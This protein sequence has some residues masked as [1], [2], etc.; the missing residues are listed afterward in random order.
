MTGPTK[1]GNKPPRNTNRKVSPGFTAIEGVPVTCPSC[2]ET[3]PVNFKNWAPKKIEPYH[4]DICRSCQGRKVRHR[5]NNREELLEQR[6]LEAPEGI[7]HWPDPSNAPRYRKEYWAKVDMFATELYELQNEPSA[8]PRLKEVC[9]ELRKVTLLWNDPERGGYQTDPQLAYMTFTAVVSRW[10]NNWKEYGEIHTEDLIPALTADHDQILVIAT[11]NSGKS[12]LAE[13]LLTW[14]LFR[15]PL[16]IIGAVSGRRT[17]ARRTQMVVR[18]FINRCPLLRHLQPDDDCLDSAEQFVT[19][20]ANGKLG[21]SVSFSSFSIQSAMVGLRFN[22][23]LLDDVEVRSDRT[24]TAQQNLELFVGEVAH[25]LNP[26]GRIVALGT[27]QEG[28]G[29]SIYARWLKDD[30]WECTIA[31]MFTEHDEGKARPDLSTRWLARWSNQEL[32]DKRR[33]M[34]ERE[35]E[36]HWRLNMNAFYADERPLKLREFITV[37]NSAT[38]VSFPRIV[39][40][41]GEQL[42]HL[43]AFPT[44]DADDYF[45]GPAETSSDLS[46]YVNTTVGVDPASGTAGRDEVGVSVVSVTGQGLGV[47]RCCTGLRG[48]DVSETLSKA[49]A[50]IQSFLPSKLVVEAQANSLYPA[51]LASVLQRRGYPVQVEPVVPYGKKGER[52]CDAI[53]TLLADHRLVLLEDILRADDA[54]ETIKQITSI[55]HDAR[56]LPHD[57]RV[58]SLAIALTAVAPLL[59]GDDA[60][61]LETYSSQTLERLLT[62]TTREGGIKEDSYEALLFEASEAEEELQMRLASALA[63][64]QDELA[65]GVHDGRYAQYIESLQQNL[66]KLRSRRSRSARSVQMG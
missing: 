32:E 46:H 16:D 56:S 3:K 64:Q 51:Q 49:A 21:A 24:E 8:N 17:R 18:S 14:W 2:E 22:R 61:G 52:I 26:G 45:R 36:L 31:R 1:R 12:G 58:D 55:T 10:V 9:R 5:E 66:S 41:G 53:G 38:S 50:L 29:R 33:R 59:L 4:A 37:R 63:T 35:W 54:A 19:P 42:T 15:N 6:A 57:D 13:I 47:I 7:P 62:L 11:R 28:A 60:D 27:P 25:L 39:R 34:S 30:E 23:V 44:A 43:P 48:K 20:Q 40:Y 65:R